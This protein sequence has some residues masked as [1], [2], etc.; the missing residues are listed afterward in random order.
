[1]KT[2]A[3]LQPNND[4][5]FTISITAPVGDWKALQ[6]Q[7]EKLNANSAWHGW[8]LSTIVAQINNVMDRLD[9]VYHA[10]VVPPSP[11]V[12]TEADHG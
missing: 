4:L 2:K 6:R 7:I 3:A 1:M 12:T 11:Q 10:D 9:K 8:P 5:E